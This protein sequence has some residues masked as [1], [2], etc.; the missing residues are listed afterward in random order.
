M[1]DQGV[2]VWQCVECGKTS[3]Y[4]T[5]LKGHVEANHLQGLKIDCPY[6]EKV[7]KSR[8]SLRNHVHKFHK[9]WL[10]CIWQSTIN[11][12]VILLQTCFPVVFEKIKSYME[13]S[14]DA[15][16]KRVVVCRF[17]GFQSRYAT[18]VRSHVEV[19][20][21]FALQSKY[22]K[23]SCLRQCLAVVFFLKF[24]YTLISLA[25]K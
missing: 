10:A 1:D 6:C 25:I 22:F 14:Y 13:N 18:N 16:G 4:I 23:V 19:S 8:G 15:D 5:N 17:C 12:C 2:A 21:M 3:Q 7:F 24:L 9:D 11:N 20:A